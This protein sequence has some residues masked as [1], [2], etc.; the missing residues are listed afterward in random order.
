MFAAVPLWL[1]FKGRTLVT[2]PTHTSAPGSLARKKF[3]FTYSLGTA[4]RSARLLSL[5][6]IRAAC[7]EAMKL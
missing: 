5:R 6:D 1:H 4:V 7:R 2:T 3:I